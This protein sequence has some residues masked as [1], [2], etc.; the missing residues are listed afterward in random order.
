MGKYL[1]RSHGD[2]LGIAYKILQLRKKKPPQSRFPE[3]KHR[4]A[5]RD[6]SSWLFIYQEKRVLPCATTAVNPSR[7]LSA[8]SSGG[9]QTAARQQETGNQSISTI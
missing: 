5:W 7:S 6:E 8:F 3:A 4:R 2:E 1:E 9:V